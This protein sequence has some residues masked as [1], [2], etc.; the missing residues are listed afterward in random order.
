MSKR[1]IFL[2]FFVLVLGLAGSAPAASID[3]S[4]GS[5]EYDINGVEITEWTGIG[6]LQ[7]WTLRD[8]TG[9]AGGWWGVDDEWGVTGYEAADG[10]VALFNVTGFDP[11]GSTVVEIYQ[12][13][14]DADAVIAANHRYTL[15]FN[16][17]RTGATVTPIAYGALYYVLDGNDVVLADEARTL[18]APTWNEPDYAG[19]EEIKVVYT[20]LSGAASIGESLGVKLS[21]PYPWISGYPVAMDNVRVDWVW[22]AYVWDPIP[23]DGAED[24]SKSPTLKWKP[25]VWA[26]NTGGHLVFL[27]TDYDDVNDATTDTAGIYKDA[28]DVNSYTPDT[29]VLGKTYYWRI[30]EVNNISDPC[31]PL[32]I[33]PSPWKGEVWSFTVT[34]YATNPQPADGEVDVPFLN[35]TLQWTAGTEATSHDVYFGSSYSNVNNADTSTSGVYRGNKTVTYYLV[36]ESTSTTGLTAGQTYY[37]RIDERS[38]PKLKGKIWRFMIGEFLIVDN[39]DGYANNP[40]LYAVWDDYWTNGTKAEI[41]LQTA[42]ANFIRDGNSLR[43]KYTNTVKSGA[44]YLQSRID[45]NDPAELEVGKNWTV[46][47]VKALTLYFIGDATNTFPVSGKTTDYNGSRLWVQLREVGTDVKVVKHTDVNQM[48]EEVWHE[49]NIPLKTFSDA[50]V[51]LSNLDCVSIGIGGTLKAGQSL[52]VKGQIH[53]DDIRLYPPRC[54]PELAQIVGNLNGDCIVDNQDLDIFGGD[55]LVSDYN[56]PAAPP[57]NP[58][59]VWYRFDEGSGST[60]LHNDGSWGSQYNIAISN[61]PASDEPAWTTDVAPAIDV[62]DPNYALDFDGADDYLEIPNTP[63]TNFAGT[64]NMTIAAWIKCTPAAWDAWVCSARGSG[65]RHATGI[66]TMS[67]N[68][69]GYFWNEWEWNWDSGLTVPTGQWAFTAVAIEPTKA[70]AYVYNGTTLSKATNVTTHGPLEEFGT[71]DFTVIASDARDYR[72]DGIM[73]DVRL[74]NKTL[75]IGEIM[76][77]CG[78]TGEAYVPNDSPANFA[79]KTPPPTNYDPNNPDIVNLVDY[80]VLADNWLSEYL[81]PPE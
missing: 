33:G 73:D 3:V 25:G 52:A 12:I 44:N 54:F 32:E 45:A 30:D 42:D 57:A 13:L 63:A 9:W 5:F 58:P 18:T 19:W 56:T 15:T 37:W 21:N 74:Y 26:A 69:F 47:G 2:I 31:R 48:A 81:W 39:F 6:D 27:G 75:T 11:C 78:I 79:P 51:N 55:W 8:T 64:E 4:N 22:A 67:A 71:D 43:Y 65:D 53:I 62:C 72:F 10:N 16:A 17:I 68:H 28:C 34:G 77:L 1:F 76:G 46:G 24:V 50:G 60:V 41:F 40:E 61:P 23:A 7:G 59:Q 49:W 70:T 38:N 20:A 80:E 36:P 14:A 29:L 35:L 66:G